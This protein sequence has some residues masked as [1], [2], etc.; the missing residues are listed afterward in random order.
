MGVVNKVLWSSF[1]KIS[2]QG[3]Q[4]VVGII[5]AR[6][7]T[8]EDYG[9]VGMVMVF[10]SFSMLFV[11]GGL[12]TALIAKKDSS[13]K[14]YNTVFLFNIG[15]SLTIY[16]LLFLG[17]PLIASF[18]GI[19][20]LVS[21]IRV[22]SIVVIISSLSAIQFTQLNI[23]MEFKELALVSVP[24][25]IIAGICG[26]ISAYSGFGVWSLV[27]YQLVLVSTRLFIVVV[28]N[29]WMPNF[30]F[31]T[32]SFR[33]LF[34][35]SSKLLASSIIDKI[36]MNAFPLVI[37]KFFSSEVL[38]IYSRGEQF[39]KMPVGI[40]GDVLNRVTLPYMSSIQDDN[41]K[42]KDLYRKYILTSSF[43]IFYILV[44][45]VVCAKPL[46][47]VLLTEKW[48]EVVPIMQLLCVAVMLDHI[49]TLNRNL[50]YVKGRS[51]WALK[52]EIIKKTISIVIFIISVKWG[53]IGICIGQLI[54]GLIAP[55]LNSHYTK[56]LI[57]LSLWSQYN[58]FVN[59][60]L[61]AIASAII[62]WFL[63][64]SFDSYFVQI[65]VGGFSFT[66][67]YIVLN[68]FFRTSALSMIY[69][70]TKKWANKI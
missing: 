37:G 17:A 13:E 38:G 2:Q 18:Y 54:Y 5:M 47:L 45:V 43:V 4:F 56:R 33:E 69:A 40:T 29:R 61:I 62:P 21:I 51:D 14:D 64:E 59:L 63:L 50:L 41:L 19:D 42:L 66:I 25:V 10:I 6:L 32:E 65:I 23:R 1:E 11:D 46:V 36:Y 31:N 7:L 55:A 30:I 52:L 53:I 22:L 34:G 57:G 58:C 8:P 24:A 35:F 27:V 67:I 39:G 15:V 9:L 20:K 70:M 68:F 48:L 26:I 16:I 49:G 3:I 28:I 60:F 12:T 44:L